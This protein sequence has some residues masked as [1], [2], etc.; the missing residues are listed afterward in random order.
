M[1]FVYEKAT[2]KDELEPKVGMGCTSLLF[3]DRHAHTI[4]RVSKS[5]KTF[6]CQQ[7][8]AKRIDNNGMSELQEYEYNQDLLAPEKMVRLCKRAQWRCKGTRFLIGYRREYY[9]YSF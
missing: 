8:I 1:N 6:W 9:D 3:S 2:I 4:T 5:G 7:D